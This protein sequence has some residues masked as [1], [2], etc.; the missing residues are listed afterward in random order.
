MSNSVSVIRRLS[1]AE[2]DNRL[3]T[4]DNTE[5]LSRLG[6]IKNLY[7]GDTIPE[8]IAREGRSKSTGYRWI[9]DWNDG[10]LEALCPDQGGGRPPKLTATEQKAFRELIERHQ[11]VS[12]ATIKSILHSEFD[13]EYAADYLPRK[14]EAMGLRYQPPA[15]ETVDRQAVDEAIEWDEKDPVDTTRRH[16][17]D[18]QSSRP[19]AGWRIAE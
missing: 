13:V 14:L 18:N 3:K 19:K 8:A 6:F 4:A 17:Y 5:I 1:E 15:R 10:G 11:P 7:H 16:P 12:T 2:L 9:K